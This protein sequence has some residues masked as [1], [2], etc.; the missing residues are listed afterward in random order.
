[1]HEIRKWRLK[2]TIEYQVGSNIWADHEYHEYGPY[3]SPK[4][5]VDELRENLGQ[6][7]GDPIAGL[8]PS[9]N[10]QTLEHLEEIEEGRA[11]NWDWFPNRDVHCIVWL[12]Q[13]NFQIKDR[14]DHIGDAYGL[15]TEGFD[16]LKS[17][18]EE[19]RLGAWTFRL[20]KWQRWPSN[21]PS[22][23]DP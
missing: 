11:G 10:H 8:N 1:M 2:V 6:G 7:S 18:G 4:E 21:R 5:A 20:L 15:I 9:H 16:I 22:D 12:E 23:R 17:W 14:E 3:D 13:A 19:E